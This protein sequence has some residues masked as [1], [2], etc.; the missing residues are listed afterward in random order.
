MVDRIFSLTV[1]FVAGVF[2]YESRLFS[3]KK[4][5]Q[6]FSSA[7][8]PR[9]IIYM[10]ILLSI[11]LLI[12]SLYKREQQGPRRPM[13]EYAREHWRVPVIFGL[14]IAYLYVMPIIGFFLSTLMFLLGGFLLLNTT[15]NLKRVLLYI[16]LSYGLTFLIQ[17]VFEKELRIL[18]P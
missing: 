10:L 7:F 17:F 4:A 5:T 9:I 2:L 15:I 12:K 18:L 13:R 16:P 8:F 3:A 14:F 1:L 11:L 6:T